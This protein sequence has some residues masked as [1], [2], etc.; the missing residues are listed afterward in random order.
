MWR[1]ERIGV[2][3]VQVKEKAE[4]EEEVLIEAKQRGGLEL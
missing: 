4:R 2:S 1:E 3:A